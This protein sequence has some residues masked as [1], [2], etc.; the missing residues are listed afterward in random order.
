MKLLLATYFDDLG[1]NT[2]LA[3]ELPFDALHVDLTRGETDVDALLAAVKPT[4]KILSLGE[5]DTCL[6]D[7][8]DT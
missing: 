4:G 6:S 2:D 3:V 7:T 5:F 8:F 1:A